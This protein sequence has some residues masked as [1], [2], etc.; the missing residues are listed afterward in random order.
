MPGL[1]KSRGLY[2]LLLFD[3]KENQALFSGKADNIHKLR[4]GERRLFD[5]SCFRSILSQEH[6]ILISSMD[7]HHS[8]LPLKTFSLPTPSLKVNLKM[9]LP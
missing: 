3:V 2:V 6:K 1:P 7:F 9:C 4:L 8:K 5:Y